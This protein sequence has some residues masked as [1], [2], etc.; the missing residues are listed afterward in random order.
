MVLLQRQKRIQQLRLLVGDKN[1]IQYSRCGRTDKGVSA[2]GQVVLEKLKF[3]GIVLCGVQLAMAVDKRK[4]AS[5]YW[6]DVFS[7]SQVFHQ[8]RWASCLCPALRISQVIALYL[9]SKL[10][11]VDAQNKHSWETFPEE[12]DGR[13]GEIGYVR[14]LNGVLPKDTRIVGWCPVPSDFG[15]KF[16][17]EHDFRNLCKMD[18]VNVQN[19]RRHVTSFE[20]SPCDLSSQQVRMKYLVLHG[21]TSVMGSVRWMIRKLSIRTM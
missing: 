5:A 15:K 14:M 1:E 20:I 17:G 3:N 16:M 4:L 2:V 10:K 19:C 7:S 21:D 11:D 18:A 8:L 12:Q 9:R 6:N 13:P